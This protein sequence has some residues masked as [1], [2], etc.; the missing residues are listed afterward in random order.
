MGGMKRVLLEICEMAR[1]QG[2]L[3]LHVI[4]L[5]SVSDIL[6]HHSCAISRI[7]IGA[8]QEFF[9]R[10]CTQLLIIHRLI[11]PILYGLPIS[12]GERDKCRL[13][14]P[15][16]AYTPSRRRCGAIVTH[17]A[18]PFTAAQTQIAI[19]FSK[20]HITRL[21]CLAKQRE[22]GECKRGFKAAVFRPSQGGCTLTN[23][24]PLLRH[25]AGWGP[26]P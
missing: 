11:K 22:M 14:V 7:F 12:G 23:G 21:K 8:L 18:T 20:G 17:L 24:R 3:F 10:K 13:G 4:L 25:P 1:L 19:Q 6:R 5:V 16:V 2:P 26:Y 9:E 15:T